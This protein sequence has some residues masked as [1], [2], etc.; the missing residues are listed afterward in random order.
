MKIPARIRF[1]SKFVRGDGCWLWTAYRDKDGYGHF[2]ESTLPV[3]AHR[4]SYRLYVGEIPA[5]ILVC[6][7]C[8][9]PA[10][11]KPEHLFLGTQK[12]NLADQRSKGRAAGKPPLKDRCL[13]GHSLS[14]GNL[15]WVTPKG[16]FSPQRY[17]RQCN[18]DRAKQRRDK[19]RPDRLLRP[20]RLQF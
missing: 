16:Y 18:A 7:K 1:E 20:H 17:C 11:V 5:A 3:P 10:C 15:N 19:Y 8:D 9:N 2:T 6:H 14:G 4:Y 13:N 12:E